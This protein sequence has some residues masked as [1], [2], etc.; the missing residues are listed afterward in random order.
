MNSIGIVGLFSFDIPLDPEQDLFIELEQ[1]RPRSAT[2]GRQPQSVSLKQDLIRCG[3][4]RSAG[5]AGFR[6]VDASIPFKENGREC[7]SSDIP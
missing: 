5:I 3:N 6:L 7:D 2:G 4:H 1:D